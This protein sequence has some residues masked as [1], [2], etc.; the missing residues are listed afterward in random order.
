MEVMLA[1]C[2]VND[3]EVAKEFYVKKLGL[4]VIFESPGFCEISHGKEG[5]V[6]G[7][8]QSPKPSGQDGAVVCLKVDNLAR[9]QGRLLELGVKFEGAIFEKP[10]VVRIVN[11]RDPFAN[12]LQLVQHLRSR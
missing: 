8:S 4:Q 1:G 2:F 3:L 12:R 7:L 9:E 10:G 5:M 6:I 11:F